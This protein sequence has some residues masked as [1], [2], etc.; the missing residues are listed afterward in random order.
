[1]DPESF[2]NA[3]AP[4]NDLTKIGREQFAILFRIADASR[5]GLVSW[6]DFTVFETL[7]KRPD[8]DYWMAFRYF[9]VQVLSQLLTKSESHLFCRDHSGYIDYN[10]FKTV[11]SA[12][13][14]PDA[15]PFDFDCDW[16]KLYLG[17]KNGTH[18]LGCM[19]ICCS[20]CSSSD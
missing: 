3:I 19:F 4:K 12:N 17:K 11:F 2:V 9:D 10:E 16:I 7:L 6:E 14:G 20:L 8:A 13:L 5:R 18:V 1:L 15:I